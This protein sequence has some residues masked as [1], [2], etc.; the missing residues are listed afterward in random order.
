MYEVSE[1]VRFETH[2]PSRG[3]ETFAF[4]AGRVSDPSEDER[5][6]L[7]FHLIPAGLASRVPAGARKEK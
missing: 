2:T 6:V 5:Y 7:E 3:Q 1:D 4:K